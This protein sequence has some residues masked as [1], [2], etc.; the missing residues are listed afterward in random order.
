MS[1]IAQTAIVWLRRARRLMDRLPLAHATILRRVKRLKPELVKRGNRIGI[2][3]GRLWRVDETCLKTR[4]KR[5]YLYR[6]VDRGDPIVA[7]MLRVKRDVSA[8]Q[9]FVLIQTSCNPAPTIF[10]LLV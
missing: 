1:S 7:F 10:S 6:A 3:I 5:V 8:A 2:S 9:A 4:G